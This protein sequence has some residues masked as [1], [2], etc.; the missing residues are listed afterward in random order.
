[1]DPIELVSLLV[2]LLGAAIVLFGVALFVANKL[3]DRRAQ[4]V[5]G[6]YLVRIG[7]AKSRG[8]DGDDLEQ[9]FDSLDEAR[10]A[11][12]EALLGRPER[13]VAHVLGQRSDGEWDVI[14]RVEVLN[15]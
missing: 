12:N 5:V 11:A 6:P 13:A 7:P 8:R 9:R 15:S 2:A 1:M 10:V 3:N 14:D 4:S